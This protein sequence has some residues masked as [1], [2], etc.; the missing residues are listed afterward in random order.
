MFYSHILPEISTGCS[1][2]NTI[3]IIKIDWKKNYFINNGQRLTFLRRFMVYEIDNRHT[4]TV[5]KWLVHTLRSC[6]SL[7]FPLRFTTNRVERSLFW[8]TT[9]PLN[10]QWYRFVLWNFATLNGFVGPRNF[11][12]ISAK[13]NSTNESFHSKL[14]SSPCHKYIYEGKSFV[15]RIN[16]LPIG[17][18]DTTKSN[19]VQ[20]MIGSVSGRLSYVSLKQEYHKVY[21]YFREWLYT[22]GSAEF[23]RVHR[24]CTNPRQAT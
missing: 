21:R 17:Y 7:N 22:S 12:A 14:P 20:E 13:V 11:L 15:L 23:Q 1:T 5:S 8:N 3:V 18:L 4:H 19:I 10:S 6:G 2:E 9:L 24:V 16:H